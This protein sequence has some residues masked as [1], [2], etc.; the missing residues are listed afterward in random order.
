MTDTTVPQ[1][2]AFCPNPDCPFHRGPAASWRWVRNGYFSRQCSPRRV[3]RF[4]CCHCRRHFSEQTFRQ[5][6]P[7]G[8]HLL[9]GA[10]KVELYSDEHQDYPR[11]LRRLASLSVVHHT[12]SS[13]AARTSR[14]PLFAVNLLDLLVRHGGSNHKRETIGFSKRRQSAIERLWVLLAWRNYVKSFSER[15]RDAHRRDP[16]VGVGKSYPQ[17]SAHN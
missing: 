17:S 5:F 12:T 14:N 11:A 15:K 10:T 9:A 2:P 1:T 13:R 4:R 3:Q 7:T 16:A 6:H 8:F